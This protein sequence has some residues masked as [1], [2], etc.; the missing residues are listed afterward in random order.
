MFLPLLFTLAALS[1]PFGRLP[2]T[3]QLQTG[4]IL[5]ISLI[6]AARL[7]DVIA[8]FAETQPR[9]QAAADV[10]HRSRQSATLRWAHGSD[11]SLTVKS[12]CE[13]L[14]SQRGVSIHP[15]RPG[16]ET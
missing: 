16:G 11:S 14:T 7:E 2:A 4:R 10:L 5:T 8:A 15:P 3:N 6:P 9:A 1:L 13:A 12:R